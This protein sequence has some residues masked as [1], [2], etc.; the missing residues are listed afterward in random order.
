MIFIYDKSSNAAYLQLVEVEDDSGIV[1]RTQPLTEDI[2]ID[3]DAQGRIFG[4]EF[5][6]A[7]THL[8]E[9][10]LAQGAEKRKKSA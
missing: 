8:P 1:A 2:N 3:Y 10:L 4:I 5:L 7:S 9:S 6:N